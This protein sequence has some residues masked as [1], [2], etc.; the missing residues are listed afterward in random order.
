MEAKLQFGRARATLRAKLLRRA[1]RDEG[2]RR[3]SRWAVIAL[4]VV[5]LATP[6]LIYG[7]PDLMYPVAPVIADEAIEGHLSLHAGAAHAAADAPR[8][9]LR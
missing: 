3:L 1:Q 4:I 2:S 8:S 6:L 5:A 7:G 9:T